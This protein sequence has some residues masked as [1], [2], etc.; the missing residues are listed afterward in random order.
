MPND[1]LIRPLF[2]SR[3]ADTSGV[4]LNGPERQ[5]HELRHRLTRRAWSRAGAVA[6]VLQSGTTRR[7]LTLTTRSALLVAGSALIAVSVAIT[8]WTELGPGPLD[9]FIGAVRHHTGLP[10]SI[11]VWA[12]VG[13]LIAV[14]SVLGRRPGPGTFIS[15]LLIG[16]V[17][18]AALAALE[19]FGPP[20]SNVVRLLLQCVAIAGIGLG[21]GALIVSGLGAGSGELLAGAASDRVQRPETAVRFGCEVTWIVLGV[22]LGGPAG[23][24]TVMVAAAVGPAVAKGYGAVDAMAARS[25]HGIDKRLAA[26]SATAQVLVDA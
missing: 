19:S 2:G 25:A 15:P 4:T 3:D 5:L 20:N 14:A 24:G 8:L 23:V 9:V 18:Q 13:S 11:A 26:V 7:V 1:T 21:A 17:L 16:P 22:A 6:E 10:L 12:T